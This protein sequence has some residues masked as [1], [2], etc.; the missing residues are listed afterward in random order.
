MRAS[1]TCRRAKTRMKRRREKRGFSR[2]FPDLCV[3]PGNESR[4]S[5]RNKKWE[6]K[7]RQTGAAKAIKP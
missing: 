5:G 4:S 3:N 7:L 1:K 2:S 6:R